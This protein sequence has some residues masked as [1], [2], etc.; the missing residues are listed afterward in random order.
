MLAC[1][2]VCL[3]LVSFF[4]HCFGKVEIVKDQHTQLFAG[5]EVR[6]GSISPVCF[7]HNCCR[8]SDLPLTLIMAFEVILNR[9]DFSLTDFTFTS[10]AWSASNSCSSPIAL[11]RVAPC[12]LT[13]SLHVCKSSSLALKGLTL[14][15][16]TAAESSS[17][18]VRQSSFVGSR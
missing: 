4:F 3:L 13:S 16:P 7:H 12:L 2:W 9:V 18:S 1:F 5:L 8:H 17:S 6:L 11:C 14:S 15:A 10:R